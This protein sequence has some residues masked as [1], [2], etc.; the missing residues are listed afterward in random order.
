MTTLDV[1]DRDW[2]RRALSAS[3]RAVVRALVDA[4]FSDED[5]D[6][7]LSPARPDLAERVVDEF[8]LFIGAGSTDLRRGFVLL[9][10]AIEWLPFF[11]IGAFSRA[12]RLPLARRLA[13]LQALE[14]SKLGLFTMLFVGLK[15]PL[16]M[17]AF[18]TGPELRATGFDRPSLGS[19]RGLHI[20]RSGGIS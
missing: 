14:H 5:D 15:L 17:L 20:L 2:G 3:S 11:A 19:R 13:Y 1:S 7:G 4:L 6:S 16:T 10:L 8:D 9:L 18:E 12:S